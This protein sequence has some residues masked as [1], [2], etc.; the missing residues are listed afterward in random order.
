[1]LRP[2]EIPGVP[3]APLRS[4]G[5]REAMARLAPRFPGRLD[6]IRDACAVAPDPDLAV[7]GVERFADAAGSLPDA[8]DLIAALATLCGASRMIGALLARRPV[9]LR[10]AARGPHAARPRSEDELTRLVVRAIRPIDPEDVAGLHRAL[11]RVRAR[12]VIRIALRDL[13]GARV[14]E[15]TA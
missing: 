13:L 12:E 3:A 9:D 15:V 2:A 4:P 1:M 7:A 6:A 5:A 8:A 10:R 11:R 14:E